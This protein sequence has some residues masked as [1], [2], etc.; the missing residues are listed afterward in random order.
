MSIAAMGKEK[1]A[2]RRMSMSVRGR[3]LGCRE[4]AGKGIDRWGRETCWDSDWWMDRDQ[5]SQRL[6]T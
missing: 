3:Q 2:A 1:G 5:A 6:E 4:V